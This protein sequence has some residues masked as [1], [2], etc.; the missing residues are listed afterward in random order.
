L[1]FLIFCYLRDAR[2]INIQ[3]IVLSG[4]IHFYI[5]WI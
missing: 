5:Q 3:L 2:K 4:N 1:A